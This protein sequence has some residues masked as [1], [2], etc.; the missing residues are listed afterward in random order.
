MAALPRTECPVC[1][2][3][4][5]VTRRG[6]VYRHDPKGGRDPELRSCPGSLKAVVAP[7]GALLLFV[8]PDDDPAVSKILHTPPEPAGLF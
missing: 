8:S 4:V 2:R 6:L 5:A 7:A 3:D 1:T